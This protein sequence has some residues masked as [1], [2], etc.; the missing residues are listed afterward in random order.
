[1]TAPPPTR[2]SQRKVWGPE[3]ATMSKTATTTPPSTITATPT[4][5][6]D[7]RSAGICRHQLPSLHPTRPSAVVEIKHGPACP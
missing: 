2:R 1:M 7:R 3:G 6:R 4:H 5:A